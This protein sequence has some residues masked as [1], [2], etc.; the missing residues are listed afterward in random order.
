MK[1]EI[2]TE[3]PFST[4]DGVPGMYPMSHHLNSIRNFFDI[5]QDHFWNWASDPEG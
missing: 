3:Y 1:R 5:S 4:K 2:M